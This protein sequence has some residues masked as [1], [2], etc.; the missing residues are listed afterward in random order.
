MNI[1]LVNPIAATPALTL[2]GIVRPKVPSLADNPQLLEE[3]NIVE[4]GSAIADLGHPT[5]VVLG[6]L[7][8]GGKTIS[9]SEGLEI[10]PVATN[11]R[12]P[13][14]PGLL[15][16]T[17]GLMGH[18]ALREADVVQ[19]GEFHQPATFFASLVAAETRIPLVVWQETFRPMR[20]PG[21]WYQRVHEM[22]AG[23]HL[24][25]TVKRFVPRTTGASAYLK[26]LQVR[27]SN[28]AQWIPTG[29]DLK[30][31]R[32]LE[33][34]YSPADFGWDEDAR[35][36]LL[37]ARLHRDKG[38]DIAL[39][40]LKRL[41]R[42]DPSFRLAI[43]GLGPELDS[44]RQLAADL[45]VSEE[46]RFLGRLSREEMVHLYN[47]AYAALC[48]SR[49]DLL[50]FALIEASACG[51]PCISTDVGAVRDIVVDGVTGRIAGDG[52]TDA[53]GEAILTLLR[54]EQLRIRL[55]LQARKRMETYFNLPDVAHRLLEVYRDAR[56]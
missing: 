46:V 40:V 34:Y 37:V 4:L 27:E 48:T 3:T 54:D 10:T 28:I 5:T 12:F 16:L 20:F 2:R 23:R 18:P 45:G 7:Y 21:S 31:F 36:L 29:I 1:V 56:S 24:R 49:N 53:L 15:P 35:I 32:P 17:P 52:S 55:G 11:M 22:T 39:G 50:P 6:D 30:Q 51:L 33:S 44:L 26:G 47:A 14:H 43:R 38:V 41:L 8:L 13:F 19:A 42:Q 25:T 9:L